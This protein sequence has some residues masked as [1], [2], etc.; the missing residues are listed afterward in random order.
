MTSSALKT[1]LVGKNGSSRR[2]SS[3]GSGDICGGNGVVGNCDGSWDNCGGRG[4]GESRGLAR[5]LSF[6]LDDLLSVLL[7]GFIDSLLD[8]IGDG[9]EQDRKKTG[10]A[11]QC[12]P[13]G[14][15]RS[16]ETY[17]EEGSSCR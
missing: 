17:W 2:H 14:P 11:S 9:C 6:D 13:T 10:N 12:S 3:D 5:L 1:H 16:S 4:D 15:S 7:D 8:R